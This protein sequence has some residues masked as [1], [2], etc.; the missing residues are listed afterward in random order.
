MALWV[1]VLA[2]LAQ[3][4]WELLNPRWEISVKLIASLIKPPVSGEAQQQL[5][6]WHRRELLAKLIPT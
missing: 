4:F 5:G 3:G 6:G 1:L 2:W